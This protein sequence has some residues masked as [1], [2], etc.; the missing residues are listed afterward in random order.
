MQ[1]T[2]EMRIVGRGSYGPF[3]ANDEDRRQKINASHYPYVW[4][5][6]GIN[7]D[8]ARYTVD[9]DFTGHAD[10]PD[11]KPVLLAIDLS[12]RDGKLKRRVLGVVTP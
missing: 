7:D 5:T 1:S 11:W 6:S 2:V 9:G 3:Y 8:P 12:E 4:L 10:V